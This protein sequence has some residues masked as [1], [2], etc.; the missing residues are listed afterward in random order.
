MT[1]ERFANQASTTLSASLGAGD[2]TLSVQSVTHF[3]VLPEFRI[4]IGQELLL[5]TGVAGATWTV[6]RGIEGTTAADHIAGTTVVGVLTAGGLDE[7]R[8]EIEAEDRTASGI[9]TAS[10]I[11]AVSTATAPTTGQVL[12]GYEWDCR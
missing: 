4:R 12:R 8:A 6:S 3:P 9:R 2:L 7:L 1:T 10:T 11:V 5:V